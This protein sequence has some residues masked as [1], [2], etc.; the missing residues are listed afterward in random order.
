MRKTLFAALAV[1]A[2]AGAALPAAAPD[3]EEQLK[4]R[5]LGLDVGNAYACTADAGKKLFRHQ[6]RHL[7]DRVLDDHGSAAAFAFAASVGFGSARDVATIDCDK[8][9]A[10]WADL[11]TRVHMGGH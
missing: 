1:A 5:K 10:Y 4:M 3:P 7:F 11:K 8:L 6:T 9:T 2:A